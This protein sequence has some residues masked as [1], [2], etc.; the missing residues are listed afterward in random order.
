MLKPVVRYG[1]VPFMLLGVNGAAIALVASGASKLWLVGLLLTAIGCSFAAERALPYEAAWNS[2]DG[3]GGRDIAHAGVNELLLLISVGVIPV[4]AATVTV[5]DLWPHSWPFVPQVL[6]AVLVADLGITL[7]HYASHKIGP[8]WRFHAV[9]H[10]VKR[11]YGFNGLMKHP[12][13]QTLEMAAGV[14][15]LIL[16]GLPVDVASA[17]ALAV[18]VQLLLQHSNADY[19]VGAAKYV[20]AL[21][22]GHRFHHLKWAGVGDVNFGLFTLVWDHLL[23]TFSHDPARRFTSEHLGMAAK[24]DYPTAY[25]AQLAEPFRASGACPAEPP[26]TR[27]PSGSGQ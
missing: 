1:Y 17:L 23:G 2:P 21:N 20:L 24:P 7:V 13:H 10:S 26:D 9:H 6:T 3:D 18:A 22:E 5:A 19:R 16:V 8:L 11:F 27:S 12:L 25:L 15:P 14:A 4:L